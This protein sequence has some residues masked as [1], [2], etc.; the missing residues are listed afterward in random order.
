MFDIHIALMHGAKREFLCYS[1]SMQH[2]SMEHTSMEHT[3]PA[4]AQ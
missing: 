1:K 4:G 3:N 2:T